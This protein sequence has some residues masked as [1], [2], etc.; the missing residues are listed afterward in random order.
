MLDRIFV[1]KCNP[2][3]RVKCAQWRAH[4]RLPEFPS[5]EKQKSLHKRFL[6]LPVIALLMIEGKCAAFRAKV[7]Q[8]SGHLPNV[9]QMCQQQR[10]GLPIYVKKAAQYV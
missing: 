8:Y 2:N 4:S 3:I 1:W 9:R 6:N 7:A 5:D 10:D